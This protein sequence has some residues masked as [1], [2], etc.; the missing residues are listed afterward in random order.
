MPQYAQI[1]PSDPDRHVIGWYDT[2]LLDYPTLPPSEAMFQVTEAE[3]EGRMANTAG[4]AVD[5]SGRLIEHAAQ[6][7]EPP[8]LADHAYMALNQPA[9]IE[10]ASMPELNANYSVTDEARTRMSS[11]VGLYNATGRLS[12]AGDSIEWVDVAGSV[13]TWPAA[14]FLNFVEA[15]TTYTHELTLIMSTNTGTLPSNVLAI[16]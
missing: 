15:V 11:V 10:C 3:W 4:W 13:Y 2:D 9:T 7:L 1:N 12:R 5:A 16:P 14:Q 6:P 8:T